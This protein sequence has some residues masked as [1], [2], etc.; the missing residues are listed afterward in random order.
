MNNVEAKRNKLKISLFPYLSANP[1][2]KPIPKIIKIIPPALNRPKPADRGSAP[3]K[4]IPIPD[5][6][7]K[8]G[9]MKFVSRSLS[10]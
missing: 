4:L 7:S 2:D 10:T 5:K 1:L 9:L 3:K 6:I 8:M